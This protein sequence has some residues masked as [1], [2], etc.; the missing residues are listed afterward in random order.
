MR[1]PSERHL[2]AHRSL[3]LY[4]ALQR[5]GIPAELRIFGQE[6]H[7]VG[8]AQK[9]RQLRRCPELVEGWKRLHGW[10]TTV[11]NRALIEMRRNAANGYEGVA[12]SAPYFA[13]PIIGKLV[14]QAKNIQ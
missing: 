11:A 10:I 7:G 1:G 14:G 4:A 9:S 2:S 6:D 13:I 3:R 8:L 12:H 5:V